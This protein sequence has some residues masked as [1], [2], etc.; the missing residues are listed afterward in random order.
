MKTPKIILTSLCCTVLLFSC[1]Q[2]ITEA[3]VVTYSDSIYS[4]KQYKV[5]RHPTVV[6]N[7]F[8][9]DIYHKGNASLDTLYLS[10]Q[11]LP[12]YHPNNPVAT[13][14]ILNRYNVQA[15]DSVTFQYD[16]LFYNEFAYSLLSTGDYSST[17]Y[18]VIFMY[19][20]P[21]NDNNSTKAAMVGQGIN[22]FNAFT[23]DSISKYTDKLKSDPLIDLA[24]YRT[25]V[26]TATISGY[27]LL[28]ST[29]DS[30]FSKLV[31]GYKFR[32]GIGGVFNIT[33][34][35]DEAQIDLQPVFLV[36]TR[37]GLYAKFMVTRFKGVG[38]DTQKLTLQWQAIKK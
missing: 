26:N 3:P 12:P 1:Q 23:S 10:Y 30:L 28:V 6:R 35:S 5:E 36:K 33:D 38:T 20:D 19:T 2:G 7:G 9:M 11:K 27:V 14:A 32:P 24:S 18:P 37:E 22:C 25:T 13:G 31:I 34:A 8:G 4:L 16:L 15:G 29:A 21:T 17:G